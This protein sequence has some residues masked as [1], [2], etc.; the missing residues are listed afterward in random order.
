MTL[1]KCIFRLFIMDFFPSFF[2]FWVLK[3]RSYLYCICIRGIYSVWFK[4]LYIYFLVSGND[5]PRFFH[6][7]SCG[8]GKKELTSEIVQQ[9]SF[10]CYCC[11]GWSVGFSFSPLSTASENLCPWKRWQWEP[12]GSNAFGGT[13]NGPVVSRAGDNLCFLSFLTGLPSLSPGYGISCWDEWQSKWLKLS[14]Y[15]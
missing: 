13:G 10:C 14:L 9:S 11:W 5:L 15:S 7:L 1:L 8:M 12:A 6:I 3:C 4:F 2:L